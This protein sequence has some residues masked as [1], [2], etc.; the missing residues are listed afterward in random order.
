[1]QVEALAR[2]GRTTVSSRHRYLLL[3][4]HPAQL[5][6][7]ANKER[8]HS[9]GIFPSDFDTWLVMALSPGDPNSYARPDQVGIT[10]IKKC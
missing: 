1:M 6:P 7:L 4:T 9:S 3:F 10:R 8:R 5:I 2:Q